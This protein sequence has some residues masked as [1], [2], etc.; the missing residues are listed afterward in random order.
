MSFLDRF[1]RPLFPNATRPLI[2]PDAAPAQ[3]TPLDA[4]ASGRR[5][6]LN[7]L[8][9][10]CPFPLVEA[11]QAIEQLEVGDELVDVARGDRGLL[12]GAA[13]LHP[14]RQPPLPARLLHL[15]A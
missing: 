3:V 13:Q 6:Q 1:T 5:Y 9:Q 11:K 2:E 14:R 10:V 8:G 12:G 7:T 4:A 15:A